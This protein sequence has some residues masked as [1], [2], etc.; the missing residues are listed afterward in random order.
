MAPTDE[1]G[2]TAGRLRRLE[3]GRSDGDEPELNSASRA[4][5]RLALQGAGRPELHPRSS[6]AGHGLTAGRSIG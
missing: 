5:R 6:E 2:A 4:H 3:C 1:V